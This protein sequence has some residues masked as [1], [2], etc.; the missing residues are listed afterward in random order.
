[1]RLNPE[2]IARASSRHPWRTVGIWAVILILGFG[3]SG[4]L[5]SDALT[6]DFDFTNNPEAIQAQNL[7]E[8]EKLEQ[9]VTPETFVMTGPQGATT[10]AWPGYQPFGGWKG[11]GSSGK[12]IASF[13]YLA[14]Y[15]REQ[16]QTKVE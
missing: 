14:Q 6:T 3:A 4:V 13:Y 1:M 7:L 12:G 10:G 2:S 9:D 5:L 11:S 15:Q 16:S 8:Q